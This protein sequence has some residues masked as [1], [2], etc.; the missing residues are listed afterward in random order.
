M[1][2]IG[3]DNVK[4]TYLEGGMRRSVSVKGGIPF[5]SSRCIVQVSGLAL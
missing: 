2:Q 4:F 1:Y 5:P 3:D